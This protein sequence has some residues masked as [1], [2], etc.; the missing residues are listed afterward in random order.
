MTLPENIREEESEPINATF[1]EFKR[2]IPQL[3][4]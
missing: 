2:L 4:L 1:T 3:S